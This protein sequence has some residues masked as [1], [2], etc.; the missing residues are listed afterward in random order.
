VVSRNSVP[1]AE[2]VTAHYTDATV[3]AQTTYSYS[4][5]ATETGNIPGPSSQLRVTTPKS[6]QPDP[7]PTVPGNLAGS[8]LSPSQINLS[9]TASSDPVT[10]IAGYNVLRDGT[11]L[12]K[13]LV[14]SPSF[15]DSGLSAHTTYHYQV[16]AVSG[17]GKTAASP[18]ISLT[19]LQ[20]SSPGGG[21]GSSGSTG[22]SSPTPFTTIPL[23]QGTSSVGSGSDTGQS[24][25]HN[26]TASGSTG[27]GSSPTSLT[28][29]TTKKPDHLRTVAYVGSTTI[30]L[31]VIVSGAWVWLVRRGHA[32]FRSV[33]TDPDLVER[34]VVD[35]RDTKG[36][37]GPKGIW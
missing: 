20:G 26:P 23:L 13:G 21:G 1:L 33:P 4:V 6:S 27:S 18:T 16:V 12:N 5:L 25:S 34:V 30:V 19:T 8:A 7:G 24:Q 36:K 9:W 11:I 15:G 2:P 31:L 35:G 10:G 32:G 22:G 29:T 14:S 3:T 37:D 17:G 28:P